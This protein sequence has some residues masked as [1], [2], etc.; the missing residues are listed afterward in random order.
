MTKEYDFAK[1]YRWDGNAWKLVN[2]HS[3]RTEIDEEL[4]GTNIMLSVDGST[5]TTWSPGSALIH[6]SPAGDGYDQS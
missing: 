4:F 1:V 3:V 5:L 6:G 2:D